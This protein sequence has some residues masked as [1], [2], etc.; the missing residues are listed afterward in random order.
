MKYQSLHT[1]LKYRFNIPFRYEILIQ[2]HLGSVGSNPTNNKSECLAESTYLDFFGNFEF[3]F[4]ILI[5]F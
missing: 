2:F 4:E 5:F 1:I 3:F